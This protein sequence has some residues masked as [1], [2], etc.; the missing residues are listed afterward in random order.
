MSVRQGERKTSNL[1]YVQDA[2]KLAQH[3][4]QM[5]NNK[6]HFPEPILANA[7]KEEALAIL[8]SVRYNLATYTYEKND[9]DLLLRH[10]LDALAHM[11]ALYALL[12]L[13][14][15][16]PSYKLEPKSMEYW[17]GLI[18]N[19]EDSLKQLGSVPIC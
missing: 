5:C 17:I 4:I 8:K 15:N 13:A 1:K 12:E 10:Q 3:T 6:N 14:Y 9:K 7:I 19:L 11:D 2:Q 16:N 18:V